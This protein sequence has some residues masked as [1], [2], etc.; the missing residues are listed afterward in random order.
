MTLLAQWRHIHA[1][2][3]QKLLALLAFPLHVFSYLPIAV[4]ALFRKFQW[5]PISHT[6]AVSVRD[7]QQ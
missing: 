4:S 1:T 5:P 7:M 6:A 3:G 2:T